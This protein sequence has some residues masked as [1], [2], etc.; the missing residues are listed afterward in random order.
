VKS[1]NIEETDVEEWKTDLAFLV[2]VSRHLNSL[3]K[4]LLGKYKLTTEMHYNIKAFKDTFPLWENERKLHNL[5]PFP[6]L[7]HLYPVYPQPTRSQSILLLQEEN[8]ER[9]QKF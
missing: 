8:Q 9:L 4:E 5:V 6:H 1:I 7:K 2:F 3:N